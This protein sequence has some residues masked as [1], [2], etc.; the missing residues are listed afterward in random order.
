MNRGGAHLGRD[1]HGLARSELL[2]F[3]VLLLVVLQQSISRLHFS[4]AFSLTV[5]DAKLKAHLA[6][7]LEG[8]DSFRYVIKQ[9]REKREF[10]RKYQCLNHQYVTFLE[11]NVNKL[12]HKVQVLVK[13]CT[14]CLL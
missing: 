11:D 9:L 10:E 5:C 7:I 2:L 12:Y 4:F 8:N 3:V 1:D 13:Y 6:S 14:Q